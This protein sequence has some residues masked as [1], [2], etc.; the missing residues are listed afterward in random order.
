MRKILFV[1][2]GVVLILSVCGSGC[3]RGTGVV[4]AAIK[5]VY[6]WAD[7]SSQER[8]FVDVV[9]ELPDTCHKF[10]SYE[11]ARAGNT[12][13]RIEICN[14]Y[15]TGDY[16]AQVFTDYDLRIHIGVASDFVAG[17]TYTVEVNEV[18]ETFAAPIS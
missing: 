17:E 10:H 13:I 3:G 5:D 9:C 4:L 18:T 15:T 1:I 16:C 6:I 2:L 14:M 8:Y 12:T 11:V 7:N